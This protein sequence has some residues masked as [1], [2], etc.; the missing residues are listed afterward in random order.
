M[1]EAIVGEG[2]WWVGTGLTLA[3]WVDPREADL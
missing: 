3:L 2:V 1:E